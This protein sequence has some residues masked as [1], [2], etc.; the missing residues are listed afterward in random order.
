M[1]SQARP[2]VKVTPVIDQN[3]DITHCN[4]TVGDKT[5]VAELSQGSSD[6]HEMVR[7]EFDDL[8]LTVEETMTVTRASRKQIHIE[9]D[10]VKTILEKL[11]H[12]NVAAMGGGLFL[13]IDTKGSLVHA[14]WIE[15]E[16]TEPADVN[17][18]GL[19]GI[20][21][22]DTDELYEVAQH[23]RDWLAAPETVLVD[24]AWLKATEQNYG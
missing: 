1:T 13:W 12:G 4:I 3:G 16:K 6:L 7:D 10:R 2:Q 9:A 24:T 5:I 8:E 14:D 21:E 18:W 23:I 19:D 17:A 22:I 11:P 20:G 15:L